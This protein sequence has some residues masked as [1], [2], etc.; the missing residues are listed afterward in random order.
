MSAPVTLRDL[1]EGDFGAILD[2]WTAGWSRTLPDTDFAARRPWMDERLR[3]HLAEGAVARGMEREGRLVGFVVVNPVTG[4]L[5][6]IAV[7][8]DA[9]G[10][11]LARA[12]LDE[13]RRI[14]PAGL[15]L[16]VNQNNPRAVRFYEREGFVRV[17]EGLNPRS[18]LPI[19]EYRWTP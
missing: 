13:A 10:S 7:A 4:Y 5:D 16:H 3:Q 19:W 9:W 2:L 17:G 15:G 1:R 14:S 18:G 6:Q 11:G 8:P 12:L